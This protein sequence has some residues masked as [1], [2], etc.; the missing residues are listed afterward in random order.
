M[1]QIPDSPDTHTGSLEDTARPQLLTKRR[2]VKLKTQKRKKKQ[3]TH[4]PKY[5]KVTV[6]KQ[7]AKNRKSEV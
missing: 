5:C 7:V 2:T 1:A 4:L 6:F 3:P